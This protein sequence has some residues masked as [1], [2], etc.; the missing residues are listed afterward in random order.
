MH[1]EFYEHLKS[2]RYLRIFCTLPV[3][4]DD[5]YKPRP[6]FRQLRLLWF[7][8]SALLLNFT[9]MLLAAAYIM[10]DRHIETTKVAVKLV[11]I[12]VTLNILVVTYRTSEEFT[13]CMNLI[14]HHEEQVEKWNAT[15]QYSS[16]R[17]LLVTKK[18]MI[19]GTSLLVNLSCFLTENTYMYCSVSFITYNITYLISSI[20]LTQ[21]CGLIITARQ[22]LIVVNRQLI[23]I[24]T[25]RNV[26]NIQEATQQLRKLMSYHYEICD[27]SRKINEAFSAQLLLITVRTFVEFFNSLHS[28]IKEE[29][30]LLMLYDFFWSACAL[31]EFIFMLFTCR[32]TSETRNTFLLQ[33]K[34]KYVEFSAKGVFPI[35]NKM[36]LN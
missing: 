21:F 7:Y 3:Y 18:I 5:N 9:M 30:H 8:G 32:R 27:L 22:H 14:L 19:L 4:Y 31:L 33:L 20:I 23:D 12:G 15:L 1:H 34:H 26:N 25:G 13:K 2:S 11:K 35:D 6:R 10:N 36:F 17:I 28:M 24:V 16:V 29:S